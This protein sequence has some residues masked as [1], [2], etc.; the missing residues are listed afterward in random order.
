MYSP[1]SDSFAKK[2]S[3]DERALSPEETAAL[4]DD[5]FAT[6]NPYVAPDGSSVVVK[7]TL[8]EIRDSFRKAR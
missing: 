3:I 7:L 1:F 6:E 5:L 4:V 2:A 8:D